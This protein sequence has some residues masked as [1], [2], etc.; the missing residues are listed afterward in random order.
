MD[1]LLNIN[2]TTYKAAKFDL[3]LVCDFEDEGIAM[4]DF[5]KKMFGAVRLYVAKSA[6]VSVQ[7]SGLILTEHMKNG[8]K[9]DDIMDTIMEEMKESGFFPTEQ[10]GEEQTTTTRTRK[11]KSESEEVIS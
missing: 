6:G 3:N 9:L 10:T 5:G 1:R 4:E 2:G 8:G 7:Q 11:K